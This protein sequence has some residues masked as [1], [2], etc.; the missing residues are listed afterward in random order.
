MNWGVLDY[1]GRADTL[2]IKSGKEK[3]GFMELEVENIKLNI[4]LKITPAK[5]QK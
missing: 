4:K 3:G 1:T 2:T 5:K